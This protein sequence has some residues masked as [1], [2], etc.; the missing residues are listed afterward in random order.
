MTAVSFPIFPSVF[1]MLIVP[2]SNVYTVSFPS[3]PFVEYSFCELFLLFCKPF[4]F[5]LFVPFDAFSCI[6]QFETFQPP[7]N[8]ENVNFLDLSWIH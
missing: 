3:L 2:A 4:L 6:F 8:L 7:E 5:P 1:F